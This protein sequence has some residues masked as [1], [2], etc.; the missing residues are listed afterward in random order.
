MQPQ[1]PFDYL[2]L[3]EHLAAF[4]VEFVLIGGVCAV[5]QGAPVTTFDL[6]V[7]YAM[8][9]ANIDRIIMALENI[10]AYHREPG[11]RR[12]APKRAILESGGPALFSTDLGA[13]DFL[14]SVC[15]RGMDDVKLDT[16][17]LVLESGALIPMLNLPTL[18]EAKAAAGR[19]KDLLV[20][21][22]L[23]ETL[24]ERE[25]LTETDSELK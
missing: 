18:I 24:R 20:L 1:R 15:G 11:T 25:R 19:P 13:L 10:N 2:G 5:A 7:L 4:E 6:D 17:E 9:D 3:L 8:S 16:D 14:G 12:L 22:I 23:R 21:P